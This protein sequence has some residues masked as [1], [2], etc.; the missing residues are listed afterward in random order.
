MTQQRLGSLGEIGPPRIHGASKVAWWVGCFRGGPW[1]N[2]LTLVLCTLYESP[3]DVRRRR[4]AET[5]SLRVWT[6]LDCET[7]TAGQGTPTPDLEGPGACSAWIDPDRHHQGLGD[8]SGAEDGEFDV[9]RLPKSASSCSA[10][11]RPAQAPHQ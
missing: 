4:S 7:A 3:A 1:L 6:G 8:L 10:I 11:A 9:H 2:G 5:Q